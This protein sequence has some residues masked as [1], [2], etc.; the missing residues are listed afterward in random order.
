M[1]PGGRIFTVVKRAAIGVYTD[2]FIHAGN[3]A[4]LA[5][6]TMFPFFIVMAALAQLFGRQPDVLHAVSGL[7]QTMPASVADLLAKPIRDVLAGRSGSL[8]WLGAIVGLWTTGSFVETIRDILYRAYGTKPSRS[9]W[10]YRLGSIA[11]IVGSVILAMAAF[12]A[13]VALTAVEQFAWRILPFSSTLQPLLSI[14]RLAPLLML[15]GA[16]Y[17]MFLTLT[18]LRYRLSS[19]PKW[20]GAMFTAFWWIAVTM[21]LPPAVAAFGGYGMTY[22]SLAGVI[23][24]LLF[25]WL[26]GL[27]IVFGAHLNAA[28]AEG[29][30]P[31][32]KDAP[33]QI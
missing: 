33:A 21:A 18:P 29:T 24:T 22:G 32:V 30:D 23:V 14:S 2:G 26:I 25:F 13:Q 10:H 16:L 19:C 8:L 3:I 11:I 5:L 12:S 31:S 6:L 4:Y 20:P 7:L 27:G 9:F 28:L 15:M 1:R 17:A